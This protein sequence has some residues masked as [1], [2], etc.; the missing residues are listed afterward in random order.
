MLSGSLQQRYPKNH[1]PENRSHCTEQQKQPSVWTRGGRTVRANQGL[2]NSLRGQS[3]DDAWQVRL[4]QRVSG[5]KTIRQGQTLQTGTHRSNTLRGRTDGLFLSLCLSLCLDSVHQLPNPPTAIRSYTHTVQPD[6]NTKK[7]QPPPPPLSLMSFTFSNH[8][9]N[10]PS[11]ELL[12][13][14]ETKPKE[15][16]QSAA[17]APEKPQAEPSLVRG[18][19]KALRTI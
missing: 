10:H 16:R 1:N 7:P 13:Q 17:P 11:L 9:I 19:P 5:W 18:Q 6:V 15:R 8:L 14:K 3:K 12:N 4:L 2:C